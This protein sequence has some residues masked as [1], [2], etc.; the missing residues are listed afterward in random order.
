MHQLTQ[1]LKSGKMEILEVPFP[2]LSPGQLLVRNFYSVISAGTE[3]K[4]VSD[5]RKSYIAKARSRQKEV[6]QVVEMIKTDGLKST[7]QTVMNKLEAPSALGYSCVGEVLSVGANVKGFKVGDK[8]ACGGQ[9]AYHAEVVSVFQN[10]CVKVPENVDISHA[11]F[12]TIASIAIQGIRQADLRLGENCVVIGLGLIGQL[13]VQL[14]KASGIHAIGIDI[15]DYQVELAHES[16][17]DLSLNRSGVDLEKVILEATK[18]FG[19]DAVIIT[20]GSGSTDPVDLAGRLCRP[21]GKVVIVGS[22]PTGFSREFYYKKELDLR[23]SCSY[24]PG[25]YD[26]NY[27]E[28]GIDYP[29]GYIRWT[30]NR[31]M[32]TYLDLLSNGLLKID[33]LISHI[34]SL[35]DAPEAY[36]M[37]LNKSERFTGILIRYDFQ[38]EIKSKV[39]LDNK[40]YSEIE[41]NVGFIGAGSFAQNLLLPNIKGKANFIGV[42][43]SNGNSARNIA[44]KYGFSYASGNAD[45]LIADSK[46]NTVF[47]ATRHNLHA[48][49]ILKCLQSDKNIFVEKPLCMT[50]EELETI[51][52]DY[53]K[54]NVKLLVGFNRRFAPQIVSIKKELSNTTPK[55]INYRINAGTLPPTHWVQDPEIGGGRIIGEVCHFIDLCMHIAGGRISSVSANSITDAVSLHD[56]LT[57]NLSF[58]NGSVASVCYFSNGNKNLPKEYLEVFCAGQV[59]IIDDFKK[60]TLYGR[61]IKSSSLSKQDKGHKSEIDEFLQSI[62][63]GTGSPISFEDIYLS[64]LATFAVIDSLKEGRTIHLV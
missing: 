52:N 27:E 59:A 6:K 29:I 56:T 49:F 54:K 38:K 37:I 53:H 64:T 17:A 45:E 15:D 62:K 51:K 46:I 58:S 43:T 36:N 44:D 63:N 2:A 50:K 19:T 12:T 14:L 61:K 57:V 8:V 16:G 31:N 1:Q 18:G 41:P 47:I 9:G 32:Q 22:V 39:I 25:R 34:F 48:E 5:A 7:Y 11:A 23:M 21:K 60:M 28:K 42:A 4:T 33:R 20:A 40:Q 30:E 3:G 24:G 55:S 35:H 10:L 13:T 26:V